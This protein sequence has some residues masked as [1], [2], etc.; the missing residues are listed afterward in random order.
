[1]LTTGFDHLTYL[2]AKLPGLGPRSAKRI[3]LH[4]LKKRE[5][6]MLPLIKALTDTYENTVLCSI[7]GNF[8]LKDPCSICQDLKRDDSILCVVQDLAD[9]WALERSS[10]FKGKYHILGGL[11]SAIDGINPEHLGLEK[12]KKRI[13]NQKICEIILA[14][15]TTIDGQTTAHYI[16]EIIKNPEIRISGLAHGVPV[17]GELDYLDE[18]TIETAIKN[19][20]PF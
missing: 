3:I 16:H 7:C 1:M 14:L 5:N 8:D 15:P 2:L 6:V 4:L 18:G 12:L 20:K 10:A 11:L 17:G 19:R 13:L 9:L